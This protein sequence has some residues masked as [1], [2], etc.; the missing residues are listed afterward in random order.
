VNALAIAQALGKARREGRGWRTTCPVH[1]G[2]SLTLADGRDG[3]LLVK[4]WGGGCSAEEIFTELRRLGL[5]TGWI[6]HH[7]AEDRRSDDAQHTRWARCIWDYAREARRTPVETYLRARGIT[8]AAPPSLRWARSCTHRP[9][10]SFLPAMIAKVVNVDDELV[11]AHRTYLLP[12]GSGKAAVDPQDQKMSLGPVAGGAVRL[13]SFDP[14]RALIVGEGI[15]STWSLMQLRGLPGWA[16]LST[17]GLK[18]LALPRAVTR[19]LIA[20][21]H[22]RNGAGEAAARD[23][24]QRWLAEGR[25][26]RLPMPAEFGDWNDVVRCN[27]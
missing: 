14:D 12:D 20:V 15:E 26:V 23:A 2:Y 27:G 5:Y 16:A 1:N 22:D 25:E 8:I 10:D 7:D 21:D 13:G 11:A 24:G 3:K 4:C 17:S 19:V 9:T 18:S 6:A